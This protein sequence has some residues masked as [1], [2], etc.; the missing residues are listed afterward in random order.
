ML[1]YLLPVQ[2]VDMVIRNHTLKRMKLMI[3]VQQ[4][5]DLPVEDTVVRF[6]ERGQDLCNRLFLIEYI[7]KN[8][9]G[10]AA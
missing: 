1:A 4:F 7:K 5:A 2:F 3:T 8:Y 9:S 10:T 6:L